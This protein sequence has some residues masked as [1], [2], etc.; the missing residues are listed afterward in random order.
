MSVQGNPVAPGNPIVATVPFDRDGA[1]HGYLRLPYSRDASAWGSVMIPLT[2]IRHGEG[3]TA[4]LTG[5]NHGDEYE[6]P[7]ALQALTHELRPEA[8]RGR[9]IVLPFL[10][11]PAFLAGRRTSPYDGGDLNRSF[12]GRPDGTPTE[13]IAHYVLTALVPMADLVLDFHSGGRTLEFVPF[14]AAHV[15]DDPARQA[16]CVAAMAAFNAPYSMTMR[17]IDAVGMLDTAVE[18][19]G[20]T[21]VTT[22]LFG[23]GTVRP[24]LPHRPPRCGERPAP[25]RH[26]RRRAGARAVD[27]HRYHRPRLLP[28]RRDS[29]HDGAARRPRRTGRGGRSAAARVAVDGDRRAGGDGA[30]EAE[31]PACGTALPRPRRAR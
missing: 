24:L 8:I 12:P 31:R 2:V 13:K 17:E 20:R 19:L 5:G 1:H 22:E 14:A 7:V 16:A 29:R 15:L 27:R 23:G 4:L 28:L 18:A 9:V 21:F 6:G 11:T 10:N 30:C 3:P 26:P 25:C